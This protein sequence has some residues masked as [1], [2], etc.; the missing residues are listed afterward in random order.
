[1]SGEVRA[2]RAACA[3]LLVSQA[4]GCSSYRDDLNREI[5]QMAKADQ[6]VRT[7]LVKSAS[8]DPA[9]VEECRE[10][11]RRNTARMREIIA[12]YGWPGM[13]LVGR[14]GSHA[15]WLL[16]QHA[17]QDRRFQKECLALM[18]ASVAKGEALKA[19]LAYLVDRVRVGEGKKQL[20]GT[21]F[22]MADG[23]AV[24][25]PI[26]DEEN[27]DRRRAEAG[28]PS[29]EKYTRLMMENYP[30]GKAEKK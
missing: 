14:D 1:M 3:I 26:E 21:Q 5:L 2:A 20:F 27:V 25:H 19:D 8:P 6:D 9:V 15:A 17:D 7:R 23:R 4:I 24:P 16:V 22:T 13:S 30:Q 10:V 18:E 29:M 11:D 12:Q 28:L